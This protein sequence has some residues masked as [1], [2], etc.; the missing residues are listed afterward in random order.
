MNDDVFGYCW[1]DVLAQNEPVGSEDGV[2]RMRMSDSGESHATF[3]G[4]VR[5]ENNGGFSS[6]RTS[7]GSGIDLSQFSGFYLDVR[8]GDETSAG[9]EYLLVVKDDEAAKAAKVAA[10]VNNKR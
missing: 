1:R 6:V 10:A 4:T 5:L 7:F 2:V 8:P 9:K 3:E